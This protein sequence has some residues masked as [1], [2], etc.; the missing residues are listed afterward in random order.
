MATLTITFPVAGWSAWQLA[1]LPLQGI[2]R[3]GGDTLYQQMCSCGTVQ[4]NCEK[5]RGHPVSTSVFMWHC[6]NELREEEGTPCIN[7][8]VHVALFKRIARRGGDPCINKCVHVALFKP[9]HYRRL[10]SSIQLICIRI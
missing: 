7:K 10:R 9:I 5:R 2:A 8:C 4:T 6:S 3:R 1:N